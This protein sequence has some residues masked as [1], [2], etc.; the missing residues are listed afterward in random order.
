M[1]FNQTEMSKWDYKIPKKLLQWVKCSRLFARLLRARAYVCMYVCVRLWFYYAFVLIVAERYIN[2]S[3]SSIK[4][5]NTMAFRGL[6]FTEQS[7]GNELMMNGI[8]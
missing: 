2:K 8:I 6:S 1:N 7:I 4:T 5:E 3:H